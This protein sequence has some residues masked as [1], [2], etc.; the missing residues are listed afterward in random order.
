[1]Q[2]RIRLQETEGESFILLCRE[3]VGGEAVAERPEG[4]VD[5]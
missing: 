3:G 5:I 4:I 2:A 1:M